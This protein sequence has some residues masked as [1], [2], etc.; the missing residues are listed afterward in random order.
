MDELKSWQEEQRSAYLYRVLA[1]IERDTPRAKL[2]SEL[3]REAESQSHIWTDATRRE[4]VSPERVPTR[5]THA[6]R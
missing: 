3:A 5:S 4:G 1:E 6:D 2:F